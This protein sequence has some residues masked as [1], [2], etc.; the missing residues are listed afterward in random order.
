M[1]ELTIDVVVVCIVE[2][3]DGGIVTVDDKDGVLFD[4]VAV[5]AFGNILNVSELT[6]IG[7]VADG[8]KDGIVV[9]HGMDVNVLEFI[10]V[11]ITVEFLCVTTNVVLIVVTKVDV[12]ACEIVNDDNVVGY[13]DSVGVVTWKFVDVHVC[14]ED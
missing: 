4:P 14:D 6:I 1:F 5:V 13:I 12:I 8:V 11:G 10:G 2:L 3:T 9:D 7:V